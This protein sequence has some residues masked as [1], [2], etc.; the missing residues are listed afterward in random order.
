MPNAAAYNGIFYNDFP[1]K[2]IEIIFAALE[3]N[4]KFLSVILR[5]II[6]DR[7]CAFIRYF[8]IRM[9][10]SMSQCPL[11]IKIDFCHSGLMFWTSADV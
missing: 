5:K 3:K 9:R 8:R 1:R 6:A 11:S 7:T 4:K 10:A 2:S